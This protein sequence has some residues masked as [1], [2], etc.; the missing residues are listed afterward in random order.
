MFYWRIY[1]A[2]GE[3]IEKGNYPTVEVA[4]RNARRLIDQDLQ[5]TGTGFPKG[6]D[7]LFVIAVHAGLATHQD[8]TGAWIVGDGPE[9][10]SVE[11]KRHARTKGVP[12]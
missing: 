2:D 5:L 10:E 6:P 8:S 3:I 9:V 1:S 11:Y 4:S 7:S 12:R